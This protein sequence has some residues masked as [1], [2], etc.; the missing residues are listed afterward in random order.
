MIFFL[1]F[2]SVFLKSLPEYSG[3]VYFD[4][5]IAKIT[6]ISIRSN[7]NLLE[8]LIVGPMKMNFNVKILEL[9]YHYSAVFQLL[10]KV[11]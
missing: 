8:A 6:S 3:F 9:C 7:P 1:H 4:N 11:Y 5:Y 2:V 10:V